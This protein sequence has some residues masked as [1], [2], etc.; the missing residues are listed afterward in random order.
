MALNLIY[1]FHTSQNQDGDFKPASYGVVYF[2]SQEGFL[3]RD[4][5]KEL[6]KSVPL[7]DHEHLTFLN[8]DDLK[9][10]ALRVSQEMDVREVRL[11]SVQDYNIGLDGAKDL[12]SFRA[13]FERYGELVIN[14]DV[15]KKKSFFGKLFS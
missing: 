2:F 6:S 13:L 15:S 9:T 5:L 1:H 11:I 12:D 7:A 8:L 14:E 4:L 10:F 3:E